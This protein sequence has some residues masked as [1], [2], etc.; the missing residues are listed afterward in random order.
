MIYPNYR[1]GFNVDLI[2]RLV[3]FVLDVI[4]TGGWYLGCYS[5][6]WALTLIPQRLQFDFYWS[7]TCWPVVNDGFLQLTMRI[8]NHVWQCHGNQ[9]H[10]MTADQ[11]SVMLMFGKTFSYTSIIIN[12]MLTINQ[13]FINHLVMTPVLPLSKF[14]NFCTGSVSPWRHRRHGWTAMVRLKRLGSRWE[15]VWLWGSYGARPMAKKVIVD[16]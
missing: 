10:V 9:G 6:Q 5:S 11:A 15:L 4:V 12:P 8:L 3:T 16:G 7:I 1:G 14:P 2:L 13:P